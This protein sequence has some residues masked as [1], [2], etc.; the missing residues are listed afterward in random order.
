MAA[1][2]VIVC[3][4]GVDWLVDDGVRLMP[5]DSKE[6]AQLHGEFCGVLGDVGLD[7]HVL[8][9]GVRD[10]DERVR[11]VL[12][13]WEEMRRQL[14]T[15]DDGMYENESVDGWKCGRMCCADFANRKRN[16]SFTSASTC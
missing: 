10:L 5:L 3:E 13:R 15:C 7:Y 1:S 14:G 12:T 16:R 9:A 2:L 6:W 8:P 4:A 11:F